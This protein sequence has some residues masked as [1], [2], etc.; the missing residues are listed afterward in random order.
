MLTGESRFYIS[1]RLGIE[2]GSFMTGSKR[3]DHWICG[4]MCKCSKIAGSPQVHVYWHCLSKAPVEDRYY[5][6]KSNVVLHH[7][8][9]IYTDFNAIW[10]LYTVP[11]SKG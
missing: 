4:T 6:Q 8:I 5:A 10:R 9:S 11:A 3:V 2:P 1:T 7:A